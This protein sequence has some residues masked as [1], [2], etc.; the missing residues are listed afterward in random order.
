MTKT[1]MQR[2]ALARAEQGSSAA[3]YGL[4]LEG[5][6]ARGIPE[7]EI[8]PRVNVLTFQAWRAKGRT[9]ARGEKGVRVYT[10]I[11]IRKRNEA[12]G[13]RETVGT[14]PK[15]ATVFHVSQTVPLGAGA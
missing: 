11:P 1:E 14:R 3:N 2:E 9:V 10:R 8:I 7:E 15:A 6:T 13:E 5:F 12:T 4:I